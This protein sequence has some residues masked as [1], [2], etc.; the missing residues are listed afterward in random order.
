MNENLDYIIP[1]WPAP[2]QVKA[3]VT[4]RNGG[5]SV[6][7]YNSFNLGDH[8]GDD[9]IAV[10]AN[11]AKLKFVLQLP[12]EPIWL[13]QVHGCN[14]TNISQNYIDCTAD[15]AIATCASQVCVVLTADCLPLLVCD[16]GGTTVAAIHAGWRGLADGVIA[17]TLNKFKI[18]PAELLVWM[19]PAIGAEAF[20]V[21]AEVREKF[22]QIDINNAKAFVPS[23]RNPLAWMANIYT[24]ARNSLEIQG[25]GWI[26]GGDFCTFRDTARFFSHRRDGG[27]TGRMASLIWLDQ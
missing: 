18:P 19:G 6:G 27:I 4:T 17:A 12:T 14:V 13:R 3:M 15:A 5:I 26:G 1:T 11:R 22:L 9:P 16:Q 23:P 20:E 2:N 10:A 7:N 8:V 25:V 24:L 21:G